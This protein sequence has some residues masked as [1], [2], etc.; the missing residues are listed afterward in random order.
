MSDSKSEKKRDPTRGY[1]EP[2]S[3]LISTPFA[4]RDIS[5]IQ[6]QSE[7]HLEECKDDNE[8]DRRIRVMREELEKEKQAGQRRNPNDYVI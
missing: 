8:I 5:S 6:D 7:V 3:P 2:G 4:G 1:W